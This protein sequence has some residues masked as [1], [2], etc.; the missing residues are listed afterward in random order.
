M[1]LFELKRVADK[2]LARFPHRAYKGVGIHITPNGLRV[3]GSSDSIT[4]IMHSDFLSEKE[5]ELLTYE[6]SDDMII[7]L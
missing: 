3:I 6:I 7:D 1:D 2:L 4:V 5:K